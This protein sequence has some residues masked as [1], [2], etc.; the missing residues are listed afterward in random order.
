MS[1]LANIAL[2]KALLMGSLPD[3]YT[4]HHEQNPKKSKGAQSTKV[5]YYTDENGQIKRKKVQLKEL[6]K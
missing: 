4:H 2:A 6:E 3:P 5:I 1:K